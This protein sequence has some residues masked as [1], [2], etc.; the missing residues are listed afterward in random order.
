MMTRRIW[1]DLMILLMCG[2]PHEVV[3]SISSHTLLVWPLEPLGGQKGHPHRTLL[4]P[5]KNSGLLGAH[6]HAI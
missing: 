5:T 1:C 4:F 2:W 6:G 3:S